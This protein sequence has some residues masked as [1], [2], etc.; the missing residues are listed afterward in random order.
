MQEPNAKQAE[1]TAQTRPKLRLLPADRAFLYDLAR[2]NIITS[3]MASKHHYG[4]LKGG[5]ERSLARLVAAGLIESKNYHIYNRMPIKTYQFASKAIARTRGGALPVIGAKRNH[6]HEM[7]VSQLYFESGRPAD[8]RLAHKFSNADIAAVGSCRPDA[9]YN[10]P[11]TGELVAVEADGGNYSRK[12]I[13]EKMAH[14]KSVGI[15]HFVWGQPRHPAA[16]IPP[17]ENTVIHRFF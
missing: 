5:S 9:L 1:Q 3:E 16:R 15:K 10:H 6:A 4:H 11:A 13:I 7:I 17:F 2:V 14:W 12:Q 8:Y